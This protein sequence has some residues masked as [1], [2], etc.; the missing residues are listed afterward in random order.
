MKIYRLSREKYAS[1]LLGTGARLNGGRWNSRG[2]N[3]LYCAEN[4]SLAKL[5]V[6]V[7]LDF[8]LIPN[9]Y[10][11]VEIEIPKKA[12]L[13]TLKKSELSQ[14]W[15]SIPHSESTQLLGDYFLDENKYL[16]LKVPSAV[17]NK[18]HNFIINPNHPTFSKI[19]ITNIELFTFDNRLFR[20]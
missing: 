20:M 3:A 1:D 10:C 12:T 4:I 2:K 7:H 14:D 8:D 13:L 17:V 18:E 19:K 9:D 6:A 15:D 11:L 16:I 5:E